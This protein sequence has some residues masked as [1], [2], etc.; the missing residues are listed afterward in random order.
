MEPFRIARDCLTA[1]SCTADARSV[2]M[3]A[4]QA[5][6][7]HSNQVSVHALPRNTTRR[8]LV[9][10]NPA[11]A[12]RGKRPFVNMQVKS[13]P[14]PITAAELYWNAVIIAVHDG[15]TPIHGQSMGTEGIL[16]SGANTCD[17]HF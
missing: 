1:F 9:Y 5:F 15:A 13:L 10:N 4:V 12:E 17:H 2:A 16:L 14:W 8:M 6:C 11:D 3:S 7:G